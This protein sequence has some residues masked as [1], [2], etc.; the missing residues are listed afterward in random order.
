MA[1]ERPPA[2]KKVVVRKVVKKAAPAKPTVRYGRPVEPVDTPAAAP[3]VERR[4][5]TRRRATEEPAA[6][7]GT[8][9]AVEDRVVETPAVEP[10]PRRSV[11]VRVVV[12]RARGGASSS[13]SAV[14]SGVGRA[15]R[16]AGS[17]LSAVR[18]WHL[19][20]IDAVPASLV[21]GLVVGLLAVLLGRGTLE[22][23]ELLRG[24]S[25]GGGTW[26]SLTFVVVGFVAFAAGE[27]LLGGFGV[28]QPRITSFLG[29]LL[30][31]IAMLA[32]FLDQS[33]T[34]AAF[35]L[36]PAVAATAFTLGHWLMVAAESGSDAS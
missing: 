3:K 14:G 24:V 17:G 32:L 5:R 12:R 11:D 29:V 6:P 19:P 21:T 34:G 4:P 15:G 33:D 31:V 22:I 30:T 16:L 1:D 23:F 18:R 26:G 10:T 20:A 27:L 7:V 8:A 35:Y 9:T 2:P 36:V 28:A 13:L 25:S